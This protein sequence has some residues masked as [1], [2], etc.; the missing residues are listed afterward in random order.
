MK[1]MLA[2]A[3]Y[4]R[5]NASGVHSSMSQA[6]RQVRRNAIRSVVLHWRA[7]CE[8]AYVIDIESRQFIPGVTPRIDLDIFILVHGSDHLLDREFIQKSQLK[9]VQ[10]DAADPKMLPFGAHQ[11]MAKNAH[12]YDWYMYSEDDLV[13]RDPL[14]FEKQHF[15]QRLFGATRV[16]Q[17]NRYEFNENGPSIKTFIDGDLRKAFIEKFLSQVEEPQPHLTMTYAEKQI[18]L[19]RALNPHSGF[20][21]L[22][23]DQL[24]YWLKR[25]SFMDMDC[26]FI[27]P[28]ESAATLGI[29]KNFSVYK[30]TAPYFSFLEIEHLD[31]KFSSLKLPQRQ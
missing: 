9:I 5:P 12:A 15:F 31:T 14:I 17:P 1:V 4:F 2:I 30:P 13:V 23:R 16:L 10:V 6:M 3:H 26:S 7:L 8:S 22:S 18:T 11:L 27:S 25:P 29:L 24:S 28:L 21:M 20:F 19:T